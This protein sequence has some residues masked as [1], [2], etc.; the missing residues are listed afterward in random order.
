M[1]GMSQ[2]ATAVNSRS[3]A[4]ASAAS[5]CAL[6]YQHVLSDASVALPC[7]AAASR[8]EREPEGSGPAGCASATRQALL[9]AVEARQRR[10]RLARGR[11]CCRQR[12]CCG[13]AAARDGGSGGYSRGARML[14]V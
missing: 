13:A 6:L 3:D 2:C 5:C 4:V 10:R 12:M 8:P 14:S 11:A 9:P 1:S 7:A